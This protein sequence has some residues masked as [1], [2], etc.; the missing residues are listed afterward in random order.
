MKIIVITLCLLLNF[1]TAFSGID[2]SAKNLD[3]VKQQIKD[4][5]KE[6]KKNKDKKKNIDNELKQ[7]DKKISKT[8]KEI[9]SINKKSKQN[10]KK[11]EQLNLDQK[12]LEQEIEKK[13]VYL[14]A[15]FLDIHKKGDSSYLK[16]IIDGDNPSEIL[17]E[18]KLKSYFTNAQFELITQLQIDKKKLIDTKEIINKTIAKI[19]R[20]KKD[21]NKIKKQLESEKNQKKQ[22]LAS[23]AKEIKNKEQAKKKLIDDEKKLK[24]IIDE[25]VKKAAKAEEK[26]E[27]LRKKESR[28]TKS[29]EKVV[30]FQGGNFSKLK[31][32]LN[33]PLKGSIKYKYGTKR[34]DT[35][36]VWK[37]IF[38]TG[39]EG[40]DVKSVGN[41]K[42]AYA[43]WLRGFGNLII[44]DHGQGYM[45]LYGYNESVLLNVNDE[46]KEGDVIA[47]VGNTG[48]L[49]I[50]GLYFEL[51]K[52]SKP[53]NPIAWTKK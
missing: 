27:E 40:Q 39:K 42:V 16:S 11:L 4:I 9:H 24:S 28:K 45:S 38:I 34:K 33:L 1:T 30:P 53:F 50:N 26:E 44:I 5:D 23:V 51:R 6:I 37:G 43:D 7:Q 35:G 22:M 8:R 12:K 47:T 41:G 19:D 2:E 13:M 15:F 49:G 25:L 3:S 17:R 52:N 10:Q 36:V 18:Q 14:S 20:Q 48:G 32:K 46:V 29:T 21:K 31:G